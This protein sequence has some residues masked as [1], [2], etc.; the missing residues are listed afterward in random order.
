MRDDP[1]AKL[2]CRIACLSDTKKGVGRSKQQDGGH[3]S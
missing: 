2:R 3:G 1:K